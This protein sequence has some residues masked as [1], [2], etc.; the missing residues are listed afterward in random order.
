MHLAGGFGESMR[1]GLGVSAAAVAQFGPS[2]LAGNDV[3]EGDAILGR[4]EKGTFGAGSAMKTRRFCSSP[5][6]FSEHF[7]LRAGSG[8]KW[9]VIGKAG[10]PCRGW[11]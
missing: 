7:E 3:E 6:S 10:H 11:K 2:I 8:K 4:W 1:A 9:D 5:D